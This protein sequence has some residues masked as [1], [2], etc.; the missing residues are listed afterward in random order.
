LCLILAR[1]EFFTLP[2]RGFK[3]KYCPIVMLPGSPVTSLLLKH[4]FP[5]VAFPAIQ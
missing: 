5:F 1:S 4:A 2:V 3:P